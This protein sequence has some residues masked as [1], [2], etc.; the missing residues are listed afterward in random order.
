MAR[1]LPTWQ[2]TI[3]TFEGTLGIYLFYLIHQEF[4]TF[5]ELPKFSPWRYNFYRKKWQVK[6]NALS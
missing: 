5:L 3:F 2:Q 6:Q 1:K 4:N